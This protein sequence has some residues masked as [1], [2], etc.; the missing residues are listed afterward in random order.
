[1][2]KAKIDPSKIYLLSGVGSNLQYPSMNM[3]IPMIGYGKIGKTHIPINLYMDIMSGNV[4]IDLKNTDN[5]PKLL[6]LCIKY[7]QYTEF[8]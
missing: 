7:Y 5:Y 6:D 2:I 4:K 3:D 1:M 8:E